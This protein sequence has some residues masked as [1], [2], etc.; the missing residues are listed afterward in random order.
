MVAGLRNCGCDFLGERFW[1]RL[2][3][4]RIDNKQTWDF[5]LYVKQLG[6]FWAMFQIIGLVCSLM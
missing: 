5:P 1:K 4:L 3:L 6:C 2:T